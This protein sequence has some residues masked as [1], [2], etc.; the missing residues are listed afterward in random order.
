M[1]GDCAT[2]DAAVETYNQTVLDALQQVADQ[3]V[4]MRALQHQEAQVQNAVSASDRAY[5]LATQGYRGGITEYLEVLVTQ[6]TQARQK[7]LLA[8]T[9]AQQLDAW[10]LLVHALGGGYVT[11]TNDGSSAA[12]APE[13]DHAS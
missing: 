7:Q 12:G 9:N 10:V 5:Q 4:S 8:V 3:V 2:Y 11:Q 13:K 1:A 6:D